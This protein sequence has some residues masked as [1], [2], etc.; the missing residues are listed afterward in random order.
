MR[1]FIWPIA[2]LASSAIMSFASEAIDA[3]DRLVEELLA[4]PEYGKRWARHWLDPA[5]YADSD[6][7]TENDRERPWAFRYRDYVIRALNRDKPFDEFVVEQIAGDKLVVQ[8]YQNLNEQDIDRL[9]ASGFLRTA[10]DGTGDVGDQNVARNDVMAETIKIV[11]T[12]GQFH[13][14]SNR[15]SRKQAGHLS[16]FARRYSA[17]AR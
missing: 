2:M 11:S 10:P 3:Y 15:G 4:S 6:G 7:Y 12:A 1:L 16:L 9:T 17:T 14:L 5:G 8:P 13:C